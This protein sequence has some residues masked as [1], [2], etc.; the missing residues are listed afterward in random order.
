MEIIPDVRQRDKWLCWAW[1]VHGA[2]S[3][4]AN[5]TVFQESLKKSRDCKLFMAERLGYYDIFREVEEGY[6]TK[7]I[8]EYKWAINNDEAY[9]QNTSGP[10][11]DQFALG[12]PDYQPRYVP[13]RRPY[14][15]C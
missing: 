1:R 15:F 3:S 4:E 5:R 2:D 7:T 6:R 13:P 9:R 8:G 10:Y 14:L 12:L 11:F